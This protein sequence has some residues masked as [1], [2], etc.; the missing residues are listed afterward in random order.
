MTDNRRPNTTRGEGRIP[1]HNLDAEMSL[2]GAALLSA[3][4]AAV[5]VAG[6][7]VRDF[8]KPTHQYVAQAIRYLITIEAP[9]DAVTVGEELRRAGLTAEMGGAEYLLALQNIT[10]AISNAA[11]YAKAVR[12]TSTLRRLIAAAAGIADAA[13]NEP[14]DPG[15]AIT[16]AGE[17]LGELSA[18]DLETLSSFDVADV[19][20]LLDTDLEPE[21]ATMLK[22]SDGGALLYPGKVH[23]FQAEP[24]SGKTWLALHAV[25]EVLELGGSAVYWDFE[26]T[27]SGILRRALALGA[28]PHQLRTRFDYRQISGRFGPAEKLELSRILD[29]MNPDLV[30][31]DGMV[32][33]LG[34]E[35]LSEDKADD[36]VRWFDAVPRPIARTGAAVLILDHVAKDPEQRGRWAR[37]S[38]AKLG[39]VDGA[40]YQ[41]KVRTSFSRHRPG[42]VDAIVA[43]DRPG[44]VGAIGETA[45]QITIEPHADGARVMVRLDPHSVDV[46]TTDS[47]KPTVL[48]GKL[49][50][51]LAEASVPLTA[52]GLLAL[53]HS[54]KASMKKEALARLQSEGYVAEATGR[55]KTLR[56]VKQY[57]HAPIN[58]AGQKLAP[59]WREA[60]PELFDHD[61]VDT[62]DTSWMDQR[63]I[64]SLEGSEPPDLYSDN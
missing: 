47:W 23:V 34:R 12:D 44:G 28:T 14:D 59:A 46:A 64:D 18:E 30:I 61:H 22:R 50:A 53:V 36:V 39:A 4:A 10:P 62:S 33:A 15:S 38:G 51:A 49:W 21:Q 9:V 17:L 63:Y 20:A 11:R 13:Y 35:G 8:Y 27:G 55:P 16:K 24:S 45:A 5:L 40:S 31:I 56:I 58:E 42:R 3:D 6:T 25:V 26:D 43:K 54:D 52:T 60:P 32:E 57:E 2:L 37:G 1:P 7:Q 29:R 19:A 48:M 41:I